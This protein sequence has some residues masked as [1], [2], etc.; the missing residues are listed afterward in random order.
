M[1]VFVAPFPSQLEYCVW[2]RSGHFSLARTPGTRRVL[3]RTA[4]LAGTARPSRLPDTTLPPHSE[5]ITRLPYR[6]LHP[7][8]SPGPR[9]WVHRPWRGASAMQLPAPGSHSTR[10]DHGRHRRLRG[11][12]PAQPHHDRRDRPAVGQGP[13]RDPDGAAARGEVGPRPRRGHH[14]HLG[15]RGTRGT[16]A[17]RHRPAADRR[18]LHR[19][20][21]PPLRRQAQRHGRDR[22]AGHRPRRARRRLRVRLQGRHRGDVR[23]AGPGRVGP[24]RVRHGRSAPTPRRA[25][26]TTR[27]SSPP[28]RAARRTSSARTNSWSRCSRPTA[29]PPTRRTSG[30]ARASSTRAT[31]AA[32]PASRPTSST[33]WPRRAGSWRRPGC[34]PADFR[35]AVFHMPNGKFPLP[36]GKTLGFTRSRSRRAGSC[37]RWATPTPARRRPA[38]RPFWTWPI[39]TT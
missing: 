22:R 7:F 14:H 27:S 16:R 8:F 9:C 24:R 23:R 5:S 15:G 26:P 29:S 1:P 31:A 39:P 11:V 13:G 18:G 20:G 33:S 30:G 34:K 17:G 28:R 21:V 3:R 2:E 36:A 35:Y 25:R 4:C 6:R 19:L 37:P 32:S 12:H 38:S 10:K